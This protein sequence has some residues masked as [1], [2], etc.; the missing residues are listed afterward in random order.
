MITAGLSGG[1]ASG[2]TLV[3]NLFQELG[4]EIIDADGIARDVV[5]PGREGLEC[6]VACFGHE[7]LTQQ[8]R[9]DR[10][11]LAAIVFSDRTRLAELNS[12]LHPL[13]ADQIHARIRHLRESGFGGVVIVDVPLLFECGWQELFDYTI[14]VY[15]DPD[16]QRVRLMQRSGCDRAQADARINA[17]MP[18]QKK[19]NLA[20]F[21][22]DNQG[23]PDGLR[24]V[25]AVLYARLLRLR[26]GSS[27]QG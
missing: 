11:R 18:L 26:P 2:K 14:V 20:D 9:L 3:A 24:Q 23:T 1:I 16:T 6:L 17:Q 27:A 22:I 7:I 10:D 21:V 25:V 5:E 13:I 8:G 4:A 15:C 12:C 19:K